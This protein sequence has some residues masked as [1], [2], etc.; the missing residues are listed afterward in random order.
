MV[1]KR[2]FGRG[3][4]GCD[5]F[6]FRLDGADGAY[7]EVTN[8]GAIWARAVV[9]DRDGNLTDVC[10]SYESIEGYM[11]D[12]M[13]VGA[14]VGRF[15]NRIKGAAF[16]LNGKV[17]R[18]QKNDGENSLHGGFDGYGKRVFDYEVLDGGVAFRLLSPDGDQGYPGN[19]AVTVTYSFDANN[20]FAVDYH[21]ISD[22]DT[23]VNLTN[24]AYF[25]LAGA[26]A[27]RASAIAQILRINSGF[28]TEVDREY[29][30]TGK[31]L[32]LENTPLDFR[33]GDFVGERFK[34]PDPQ[35]EI[36]GGY[37]FNI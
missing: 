17:Y 13:Y 22:Q 2:I 32:P 12:T 35:M 9:P 5:V 6:V 8:Y 21:A 34:D 23:P 14:V 19:L 27:G 15:A 10:L 24:H 18:L 20:V 11:T 26:G 29:I 25:N 3:A 37:D 28:I 36:A 30:P 16:T 4:D 1:T 7:M 31:L 33:M